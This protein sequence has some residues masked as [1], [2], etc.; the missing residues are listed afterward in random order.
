MNVSQ[1]NHPLQQPSTSDSAQVVSELTN[2]ELFLNQLQLAQHGDEWYTRIDAR[3]EKERVYEEQQARRREEKDRED[4]LIA[5]LASQGYV[6]DLKQSQTMENAR[7][8]TAAEN[9]DRVMQHVEKKHLHTPAIAKDENPD[10]AEAGFSK[11]MTGEAEGATKGTP[12]ETAGKTTGMNAKELASLQHAGR[13]KPADAAVVDTTQHFDASMGN[14]LKPDTAEK[15]AVRLMENSRPSLSKLS[16]TEAVGARSGS[17]GAS[18]KVMTLSG[19]SSAS[20]EGPKAETEM[21]APAA[22]RPQTP[23]NIKDVAGTVKIMISSRTNEMVMQLAPEHLGK[24]EIRLKKEG[25]RLLGRFRVDSRE[26]K[27]AIDAQLP[28]LRESLAERGI[29]L[30][31]L[32]VF[33]R[34]DGSSNQSFAFNQ[35]REGESGLDRRSGDVNSGAHTISPASSTAA[36]RTSQMDTGLNI[37]A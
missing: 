10:G 13:N 29:H 4:G 33:V 3:S 19:L 2:S 15:A 22:S 27:E 21:K 6:A 34:G 25:D 11:L 5:G 12:K 16:A 31:E 24:L 14:G 32:T 18:A 28:Q 17:K 1:A 23:V 8:I 35:E 36:G 30:A 7:A 26:A 9:R 20:P 37:Y